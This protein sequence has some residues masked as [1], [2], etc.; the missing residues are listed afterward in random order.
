MTTITSKDHRIQVAF[1]FALVYVL[2]GSTYLAMRIAVVQIPPFAMGAVRYLVAGPVMLAWCAWSGRRIRLTAQDFRRLLAIGALLLMI[3][4]MGVAWSEVY[5]PSS[6]AALVVAAVPIWV[7]IIQT[8][9]LRNTRLSLMGL[10][11]MV[12]G[13]AGMVVLLWPRI[14]TRTPLGRLEL[15]G[16]GL[17]LVGSMGWALGSVLGGRWSLSVD[18]FASS[19]WQMTIGGGLLALIA[20]ATGQFRHAHWSMQA[21]AWIFYLVICGSWIG[22]SAYNWLLEHVPTAKVA[23]YAY[24]N[25][26]VALYLGWFFLNEKIDG[27]MLTGTVVIIAAVAIVNASRLKSVRKEEAPLSEPS[28]P[29]VE[30]AGD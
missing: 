28:L 10:A 17:L 13:V 21:T 26:V 19:A 12:L 3:G 1:A 2:W 20:L 30:A 5:V 22:Y 16:V 29:L 4:N 24:V 9:I 14:M 15:F 6:L 8:W 18:V 11:G 27:F 25:P 23:T 7:V